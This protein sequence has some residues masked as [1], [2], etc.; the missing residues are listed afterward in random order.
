MGKA[1]DWVLQGWGRQGT[2]AVGMEVPDPN[3]SLEEKGEPG[4]KDSLAASEVG[5]RFRS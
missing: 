5:T 4:K 3:T 2:G 1:D